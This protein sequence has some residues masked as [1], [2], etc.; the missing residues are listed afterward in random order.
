M[1]QEKERCPDGL[2][3][4]SRGKVTAMICSV[5]GAYRNAGLI[6]AGGQ[7]SDVEVAR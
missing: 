3:T 4:A 5:S 6:F 1:R 7:A 2:E